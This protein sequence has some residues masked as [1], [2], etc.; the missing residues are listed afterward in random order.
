MV[1]AL[2]Q[3]EDGTL[4]VVPQSDE[5][6]TYAKKIDKAETRIDWQRPAHQVHD[7]IR[8]LS[9]F[10]GAWCE[11]AIS[12]KAERLKVLRSVVVDGA[13]AAGTLLDEELTVACVDGA[14]RL[15]EV[16]RAG[17]KPLT[18]PEF[19]R[20]AKLTRGARL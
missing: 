15:V 13:G 9:P 10:P 18:A 5:G 11:V 19:L 1:D 17:G 7:H 14:V 4:N 12:G 6:V 16:Q 2:A 20:G 8:A 3:L